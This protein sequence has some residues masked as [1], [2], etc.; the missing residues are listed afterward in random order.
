M[1]DTLPMIFSVLHA[2]APKAASRI[3]DA[4]KP[5][6]RAEDDKRR[7][8]WQAVV[9]ASFMGLVVEQNEELSKRLNEIHEILARNSEALAV[10]LK[11]TER[12]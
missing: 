10:L 3:I 8:D 7:V 2:L 12:L 6:F 9:T 4:I 1:D 11:R 5:F